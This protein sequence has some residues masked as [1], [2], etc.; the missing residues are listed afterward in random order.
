MVLAAFPALP[1]AGVAT[2]SRLS[3][4]TTAAPSEKAAADG[5]GADAEGDAGGATGK[6]A[7][8]AATTAAP[9]ATTAA[10]ADSNYVTYKPDKFYTEDY[11]RDSNNPLEEL[12]F[13][14]SYPTSAPS[15]GTASPAAGGGAN[16]SSEQPKTTEA[17]TEAPKAKD[18]N[19]SAVQLTQPNVTSETTAA[20]K[21][22][23]VESAPVKAQEV[24]SELPSATAATETTSMTANASEASKAKASAAQQ[25]S[26]VTRKDQRVA[27]WFVET[28][29][30]GTP[31]VFGV[32]HR[33]EGSHC[34]LDTGKYG[35]NGWCYTDAD[36][37]AWGS[38]EQGCPLHGSAAKVEQRVQ[39]L[40]D[41]V[42]KLKNRIVAA[43]AANIPI[44]QS[45]ASKFEVAAL[46][47]NE[48]LLQRG[49]SNEDGPIEWIRSWLTNDDL[50]AS[51]Q[52]A[53]SAGKNSVGSSVKGQVVAIPLQSQLL[54]ERAARNSSASDGQSVTVKL[55]SQLLEKKSSSK[56]RETGTSLMNK[57]K[58]SKSVQSGNS[59][60][61]KRG[62]V[63]V[64]LQSQL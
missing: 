18:T 2:S 60:K 23:E 35:S 11:A 14:D 44:P 61:A 63:V 53:V 4:G 1:A 46:Q 58:K 28:A 26:C 47:Q 45:V 54:Q 17:P 38:C 9:A 6:T 59:S 64:K 22:A 55:Q 40:S 8:S 32:D 48:T 49:R 39:K 3:L 24:P 16:S 21:A 42:G 5:Q 33:D 7:A 62:V 20:T 15:N 51:A 41:A 13:S 27:A 50:N 25:S 37:S 29:A 12:S 31:C 30:D 34:I 36:A 19:T 10:T 57:H 56:P 43:K 52:I